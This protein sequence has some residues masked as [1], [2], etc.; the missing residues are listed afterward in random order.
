MRWAQQKLRWEKT[1]HEWPCRDSSRLPASVAADFV[2]RLVCGRFWRFLGTVGVEFRFQFRFQL[3]RPRKWPRSQQLLLF[4]VLCQW[5]W[6]RQRIRRLLLRGERFCF[7]LLGWFFLWSFCQFL[8][9]S[10]KKIFLY[11]NIMSKRYKPRRPAGF[12]LDQTLRS[13]SARNRGA[14]TQGVSPPVEGKRRKRKRA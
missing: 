5:G 10:L 7:F 8:I 13:A 4:G 14:E 1:E 11:N 2:R 3:W 9:T 12:Q 6:C